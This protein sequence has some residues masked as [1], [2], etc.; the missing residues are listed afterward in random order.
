MITEFTL[1]LMGIKKIETNLI[2]QNLVKFNAN[3]ISIQSQLNLALEQLK[4]VNIDNESDI[5]INTVKNT[6]GI[7]TNHLNQLIENKR[8]YNEN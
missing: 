3:R 7:I 4:I 5:D 8:Q 1:E 6:I 2:D